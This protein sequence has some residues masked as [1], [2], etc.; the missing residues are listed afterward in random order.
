MKATKPNGS[1]STE[2]ESD[3][4]QGE[5]NTEM[6]GP[7]A[8]S[9]RDVMEAEK[10][11]EEAR[12]EA[13]DAKRMAVEEV[14]QVRDELEETREQL[15]QTREELVMLDELVN[16]LF[17]NA[18]TPEGEAPLNSDMPYCCEENTEA[19]EPSLVDQTEGDEDE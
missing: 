7:E 5:Q 14:K 4:Q 2:M 10:R 6:S 8:A 12:Q 19:E 11:A 13:A 16:G 3:P 18:A 9:R 15:E 1:D 17:Q